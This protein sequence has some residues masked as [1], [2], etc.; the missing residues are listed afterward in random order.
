M[1][2]FQSRADLKIWS[3]LTFQE[4]KRT[5]FVLLSITSIS[6]AENVD[7]GF[8][9]EIFMNFGLKKSNFRST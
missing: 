4:G 1:S 5:F 9:K 2:T 6:I 7:A 8:K 3:T